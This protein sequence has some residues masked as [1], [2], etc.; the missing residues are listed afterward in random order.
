[1][2]H[3]LNGTLLMDNGFKYVD[4]S[5]C[6]RVAVP[7]SGKPRARGIAIEHSQESPE[8]KHDESRLQETL[9][10]VGLTTSAL[11]GGDNRDDRSLG[12]QGLKLTDAGIEHGVLSSVLD[13]RLA[14]WKELVRRSVILCD[15]I[16]SRT[17]SVQVFQDRT[18]NL[19]HHCFELLDAFQV[20][21]S[22]LTREDL[23][24]AGR[25]S[26]SR[27][28]SLFIDTV[29]VFVTIHATVRQWSSWG[30]FTSTLKFNEVRCALNNFQQVMRQHQVLYLEARG[31]TAPPQLAFR[32]I[33]QEL[34]K[35]EIRTDLRGR[36]E[37]SLEYLE[38][39]TASDTD[40]GERRNAENV[41]ILMRRAQLPAGDEE[42]DC[43]DE[44][45]EASDEEDE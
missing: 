12:G 41:A 43:S 37:C 39:F 38:S 9:D 44:E 10:A 21:V 42:E 30:C 11:G 36:R 14:F 33:S 17:S 13:A 22:S 6:G 19:R 28:V 24:S 26:Y 31:A 2:L 16:Y 34:A 4:L 32:H 15:D 29:S 5:G 20:F 18:N 35:M 27:A 45:E 1:M 3:A 25:R 23:A 8:C 7:P 40:K